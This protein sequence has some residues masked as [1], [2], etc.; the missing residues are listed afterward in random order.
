[1]DPHKESPALDLARD[2]KRKSESAAEVTTP[3]KKADIRLE[4]RQVS[5]VQQSVQPEISDEATLSA[6]IQVLMNKVII[7]S[8]VVIRLGL[9]KGLNS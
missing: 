2:R 9:T 8:K 1:M 4:D 7:K 6:E 5:G 3:N